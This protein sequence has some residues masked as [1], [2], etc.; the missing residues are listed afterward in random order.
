VQEAIE[1]ARGLLERLGFKEAEERLRESTEA[2][3][4]GQYDECISRSKSGLE[5]CLRSVLVE[6]GVASASDMD[7]PE[8]WRAAKKDLDLW[9]APSSRATMQTASGVLSVVQGLSTLRNELGPDHGRPQTP[10][11]LQSQAEL[12]LNCAASLCLFLAVRL[13]EIRKKNANQP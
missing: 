12:A 5:S 1:A 9:N 6:R 11:A 7:V 13:E 2:L 8:L 10:A 4:A 3:H